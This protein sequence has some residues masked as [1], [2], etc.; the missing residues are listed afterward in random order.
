MNYTQNTLAFK[1][2]VEPF[3]SS[4]L[5]TYLPLAAAVHPYSTHHLVEASTGESNCNHDSLHYYFII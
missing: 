5:L 4:N 3:S 1:V 2:L